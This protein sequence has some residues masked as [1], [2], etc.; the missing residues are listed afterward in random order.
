MLMNVNVKDGVDSSML[1]AL[2]GQTAVNDYRYSVVS[3]LAAVQPDL[4]QQVTVIQMPS[5][6]SGRAY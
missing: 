3:N 4:N 5:M 1:A 2:K 6:L